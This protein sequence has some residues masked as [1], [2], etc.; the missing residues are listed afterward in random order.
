MDAPGRN[1]DCPCG[2][3]KK[4]KKC[5]LGKT[6]PAAPAAP[7]Q[8]AQTALNEAV[9]AALQHHQAGRFQQ[10]AEIYRQILQIQPDHADA[11]HLLG[12]IAHQ[13]GQHALALDLISRAIQSAPSIALY[14]CNI[15]PVLLALDQKNEALACYQ[16][17]VEL[18][19]DHVE[20]LNNIGHLQQQLG[21]VDEAVASYQRAITIKPDY[22]EAHYNL[23]ITLMS[24]GR[25][26]EALASNRKAL[27]HKPDF[28]DAYNNAGLLLAEMGNAN[29][30]ISNYQKALSLQ[31]NHASAHNNLANALKEQG[32]LDEAVAHGE[33]ALAIKPDFVEALCTLGNVAK[34]QGRLDESFEYY[35]RALIVRPE[36][37]DAW[38]NMGCVLYEQGKR[39]EAMECY[40]KA[41]E[42]SPDYAVAHNNLGVVLR[43][44]GRHQEA[45]AASER[46]I[47]LMPEFA[48]PYI[49]IGNALP[50]LGR[51]DESIQ[52][53]R[54]ALE[55]KP[56]HPVAWSNLLL[57]LLYDDKLS[58]AEMFA[59]SCKFGERIEMPLK[60][61]WPKHANSPDAERRLK[62][63]YVSADLREHAL[64]YFIEPILANHDKSKFEAYCYSNHP[65]QDAMTARLRGLA[66]HWCQ[67]DRMN[68]EQLSAQIQADEIDI[69][70]DLS[71]HT[72]FN[73]LPMFARKPAPVQ[74]NWIGYIGTTGL[75][76]MDYRFTDE[77]LDPPGLTEAF[78]SERLVRLPAAFTFR[79]DPSAPPVNTLP[80]LAESVFTFASLNNP[81]KLNEKVVAL[82]A[83]ILAAVPH[84]RLMLGNAQ[85]KQEKWLLQLFAKHGVGEDRLLL[86]PRVSLQEYLEAHH[87]ID[88]ALDPF[89]YNGG[90]TTNYAMWMGVPVVVLAG[91]RPISRVGVCNLMRAGLP[92]F[93]AHS[94][95][96]Y[97]DIAVKYSR[98]LN[99]L[100][101]LRQ[102]LRERILSSPVIDPV[103]Y[104][105]MVEDAFRQLWREWCAKEA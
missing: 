80:A 40:R 55:L 77:H 21:R 57:T 23:G 27:K 1:D 75:S 71:G 73:R 66:E 36:F 89:P 54:K 86:L 18:Q 97:V 58:P 78:H 63:A 70:V 104:T 41:I 43:E 65:Q 61:G 81:A 88:L 9:Q 100:N 69:L 14:Y 19:P 49:N 42:I 30:A 51:I 92:E 6:E 12:V 35:R 8:D 60:S 37:A 46:A 25:R 47:E 62:I 79:S 15:A 44:V 99:A 94:A 76:A 10:A 22:A 84:S 82:W 5:C 59:E 31:P 83:R 7:I 103:A 26:E 11:L 13:G 34:A 98:D 4:Y 28:A 20:A 96:E 90:T 48:E 32:R 64:A 39:N 17:V 85:A 74:I 91:D 16:K 67:C 24:Q 33:Q 3:G 53:Y 68:D 101:E 56:D 105:H 93:V 50:W 45:I 95:D 38:Y 87:R 2:S 52:A 29:E 72:A 102:S